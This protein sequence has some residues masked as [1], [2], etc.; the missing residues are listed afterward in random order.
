MQIYMDYIRCCRLYSGAEYPII[1]TFAINNKSLKIV[2]VSCQTM[3]YS[4]I[5]KILLV[6]YN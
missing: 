5:V 2:V 4:A 6:L 1:W 3:D